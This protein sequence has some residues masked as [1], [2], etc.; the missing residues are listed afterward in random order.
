MPKVDKLRFDGIVTSALKNLEG[1]QELAQ[2]QERGGGAAGPSAGGGEG[3]LARG[4]GA[5]SPTAQQ[6]ASPGPA[7]D[8]TRGGPHPL[9]RK[10]L[11]EGRLVLKDEP[12]DDPAGTPLRTATTIKREADGPTRAQFLTGSQSPAVPAFTA[13]AAG[14]GERGAGSV[15]R[16]RH[17]GP[18]SPPMSAPLVPS[19]GGLLIG[20]IEAA[21]G[22]VGAAALRRLSEPTAQI[23]SG[24]SLASNEDSDVE[25]VEVRPP[26]AGGASFPPATG[27]GWSASTTGE[28]QQQGGSSRREGGGPE[29]DALPGFSVTP[30]GGLPFPSAAPLQDPAAAAES[31]PVVALVPFPAAAAGAPPPVQAPAAPTVVPELLS[32]VPHSAVQHPAGSSDATASAAIMPAAGLPSGSVETA[33]AVASDPAAAVPVA[34][35]AAASAAPDGPAPPERPRSETL[36]LELLLR[37][38]A[39][40][41]GL[42]AHAVVAWLER[43][44]DRPQ[45]M[46]GEALA[47]QFYNTGGRFRRML[48]GAVS[49]NDAGSCCYLLKIIRLMPL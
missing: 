13:G 26:S 12:T 28:K 49:D 39:G 8:L 23:R 4:P 1:L 48:E 38:A 11:T 10:D 44:G 43:C 22:N 16:A 36:A 19:E 45:E 20:D 5:S 47:I 33:A 34:A 2:R 27:G 21:A 46:L 42:P 37:Q 7:G 41:S 18:S 31:R 14:S 9:A 40:I 32:L 29:A 15:K 6:A 25:I 17:L 3:L 24:P 35:F 30:L